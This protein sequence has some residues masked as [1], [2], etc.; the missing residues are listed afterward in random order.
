MATILTTVDSSGTNPIGV[1]FVATEIMALFVD[2][3]TI[4]SPNEVAV[5]IFT[6]D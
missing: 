3:I 5:S 4:V 2:Y 1:T 6:A